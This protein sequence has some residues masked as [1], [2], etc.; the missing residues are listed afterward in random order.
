MRLAMRAVFV[1]IVGSVLSIL[2]MKYARNDLDDDVPMMNPAV[3]AEP[4]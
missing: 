3:A 1:V 2:A 4:S